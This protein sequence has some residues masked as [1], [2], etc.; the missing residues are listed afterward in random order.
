MID[1]GFND[2]MRYPVMYVAHYHEILV[3][4]A[5]RLARRQA[6]SG[7]RI[8]AGPLCEGRATCSRR[9]AAAM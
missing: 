4:L 8:V 3:D 9:T 1:A 7:R 5:R 6:H 2:L